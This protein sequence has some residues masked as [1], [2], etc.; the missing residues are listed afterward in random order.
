MLNTLGIYY[1]LVV[2]CIS[3]I[4][5]NFEVIFNYIKNDTLCQIINL[6]YG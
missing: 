6:K 2:L 1:H 3:I 4:S 5:V